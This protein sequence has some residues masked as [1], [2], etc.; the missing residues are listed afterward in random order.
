M[1]ETFDHTADIG[2]RATSGDLPSLFAEAGKALVSLLLDNPEDVVPALEVPIHVAGT[3]TDYLLFDWLNEL[4]FQFETRGLLFAE[5]EVR[6][7][8]EGLDA[9]AR[10][11]PAD[12]A[13]HRLSHE[14]KAITYHDLS[15]KQT[16]DGW[17]ARVI[18]DI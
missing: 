12:A 5:F 16:A 9:V 11:E 17:E 10:G 13:R 1:F 2:I 15:V 18:V 4:L 6:L 8:A 14:V 3:E 7:G